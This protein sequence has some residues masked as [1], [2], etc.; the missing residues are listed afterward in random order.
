PGTPG[1]GQGRGASGV[2]RQG[3]ADVASDVRERPH[4]DSTRT[5]PI[6]LTLS[7]AYQEEGIRGGCPFQLDGL[8]SVHTIRP[9]GC[10]VFFCDSTSDEWQ[11]Q[12]YERFH[13]ELKR[14]HEQFGVPYLYVEWRAAL[15]QLDL[16]VPAPP[17]DRKH[18]S[19][20]QLRL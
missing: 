9:F 10:R 19:L 17:E 20:P 16:T 1:R 6:S 18:L 8:C 13:G 2:P 15:Q 7:P 12:Q 4:P 14:L 11:H 3:P 5:G